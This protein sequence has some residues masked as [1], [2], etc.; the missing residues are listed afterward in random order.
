MD[1]GCICGNREDRKKMRNKEPSLH[2][3][4]DLK[5]EQCDEEQWTKNYPY[6][7][8]HIEN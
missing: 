3:C 7:A 6:I 1:K 8:P 2:I 5:M 4:G